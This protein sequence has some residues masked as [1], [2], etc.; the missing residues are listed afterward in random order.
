MKIVLVMDQFDEA[1]N[2]TTVTARRLAASLRA[3]GHEVNVLAAGAPEEHKFCAKTHRIPFFQGLIEDQGMCFAKPDPALYYEAFQG[4]D[5]IHLFMPFRFCASAEKHARQMRIPCVAGFH[6]QPENITSTFCVEKLPLVS[7]WFYRWFYKKFYNRFDYIHCPSQLIA[8]TLKANGYGGECRVISNGVDPAFTPPAAPRGEDGTFRIL[9][10]GRFSRE[11]RQDLLIRAVGLSK[12]RDRIHLTF[13]GQG[14]QLRRYRRLGRK[15]PNAPTF[16]YYGQAELVALMGESDLYVHAADAEAEGISCLEAMACGLVPVI[17]DSPLSAA[18][19]WALTG[20]SLFAAGDAAALAARIDWWIDHPAERAAFSREYAAKME[21]NRVAA[22]AARMEEMYEAAIDLVRHRGYRRVWPGGLAG[23][24]T[25]HPDNINIILEKSPPWQLA[26]TQFFGSLA[27]AIMLPV[28]KLFLGLKIKGRHH[29]RQLDTGAV[30][31]CNHIHQLD[32]TMWKGAL[33]HRNTWII[34]LR[35]NFAMPMIGLWIRGFGAVGL[36][37]TPHEQRRLNRALE[38]R[39]AE[40]D[41][42]HYFP[43]G[44]LLPYCKA[45]RP[46]HMGAFALAVQTGRPIL[47]MVI[48]QR[49]RTGLWR[50]LKRKPL[51]TL[52][53]LKPEWPDPALPPRR[54]RAELHD[55]TR[56]AMQHCLE[57]G[58]PRRRLISLS[59]G[60]RGQSADDQEPA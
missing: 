58:P 52:C 20:E 14:P 13:A 26:M 27:G 18:G 9:S 46:F 30:S 50:F 32:S 36:G 16:G 47:P 1:G 24:L 40:G 11:K 29:L 2:G 34:S 5:L 48:C 39:I 4:A 35:H 12:Y 17:S 49:P 10:V 6:I 25:P 15:L 51:F 56:A 8:D 31:V 41:I 19:Q 53:I 3:R 44:M 54:A 23:L 37:D 45:L 42:V 43:E 22:C 33:V 21:E 38:A 7:R 57:N 28:G 60:R 59:R 55:R